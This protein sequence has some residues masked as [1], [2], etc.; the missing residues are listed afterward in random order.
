M[1]DMAK[2]K[3]VRVR[4]YNRTRLGRKEHVREH[5]RSWPNQLSFDF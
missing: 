4:A 5:T 3:L 2:E 1:T